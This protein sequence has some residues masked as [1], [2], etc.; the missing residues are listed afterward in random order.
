MLGFQGGFEATSRPGQEDPGSTPGLLRQRHRRVLRGRA[1]VA[2]VATDAEAGVLHD[3]R[4]RDVAGGGG[5]P[6]RLVSGVSE[7]QQ[8]HIRVVLRAGLAAAAAVGPPAANAK[9]GVLLDG[10]RRNVACRRNSSPDV[11]VGA[12][13]DDEADVVAKD[14]EARLLP[15]GNKVGSGLTFGTSRGVIAQSI[16]RP[17]KVPVCCNSTGVGS[18]HEKDIIFSLHAAALELGN[19]NPNNLFLATDI[20]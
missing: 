7:D 2:A 19:I 13:Q 15:Q 14:Q 10:G 4:R 12:V 11:G 3:G 18:N 8:L 20:N 1:A 17:S 16:E 5:F 9:A 6:R